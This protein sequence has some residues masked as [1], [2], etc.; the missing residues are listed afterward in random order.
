MFQK[1]DAHRGEVVAVYIDD[2]PITAEANESVAAV[3]LR[4]TPLW[5]R[6]TPV[7]DTRR[8]PYCLMGVCFDCLATVDGISSIQTCLVP[9]RK[10]MRINRQRGR[11]CVTP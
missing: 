7:S 3:L 5:S 2:V 4:Q 1:L 10:G 9:V 8:A 6:T 11:P